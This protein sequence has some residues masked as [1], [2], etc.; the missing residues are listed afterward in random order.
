SDPGIV[1]KKASVNG[2]SVTII[3]VGREGFHGPTALIDFQGYMPLAMAATLK[4]ASKDFLGDRKQANSALLA[5]LMPHVTDERVHAALSV[6][7]KRLSDQRPK[8]DA[9][10]SLLAFHLGP[11][12]LAFDPTEPD[13]L[14][15]V[16]VPFVTLGGFVLL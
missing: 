3:G 8:E 12:G 1:G 10:A 11:A 4:D 15:L 9:W 6:V 13:A 16:S 2:Q 7:A 14:S 5:R